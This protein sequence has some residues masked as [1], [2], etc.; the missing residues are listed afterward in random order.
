VAGRGVGCASAL[1][2]PACCTTAR[3]RCR[4]RLIADWTETERGDAARRASDGARHA[5]PQPHDPRHCPR[6]T[7]RHRPRGA[8]PPGRRDLGGEDERS[9]AAVLDRDSGGRTPAAE[10]VE[11]YRTRW[12]GDI[13]RIYTEQAY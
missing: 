13:T 9:R 12:G 10:L 2:L 4:E 6:S 1:W 5:A 7:R 3:R 8:A 11:D